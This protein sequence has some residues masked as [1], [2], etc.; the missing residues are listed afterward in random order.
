LNH[1]QH[2]EK[3]KPSHHERKGIL[4]VKETDRH[5]LDKKKRKK[6]EKTKAS[7]TI[8]TLE[9]V[10]RRRR[11]QRGVGSREV[12]HVTI[13]G[14]VSHTWRKGGQ[15]SPPKKKEWGKKTRVNWGLT[16]K[17]GNESGVGEVTTMS[18]D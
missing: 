1:P 14:N 12:G 5:A 15:K 10:K 9:R 6:K 11:K 2:P 7:K 3:D 16:K 18:V 13:Q 4:A 17:R 8:L